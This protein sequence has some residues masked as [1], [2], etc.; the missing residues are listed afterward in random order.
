MT[1]HVYANPH[2]HL[3]KCM[4]AQHRQRTAGQPGSL[5]PTVSSFLDHLGGDGTQQDE[6]CGEDGGG[7]EV[8]DQQGRTHLHSLHPHRPVV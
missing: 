3:C 2:K 4:S 1:V 6:G 7:K 5:I 8:G